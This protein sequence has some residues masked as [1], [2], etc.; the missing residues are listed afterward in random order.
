VVHIFCLGNIPGSDF[1][2]GLTIPSQVA[3][4]PTMS[5]CNPVYSGTLWRVHVQD[6]V[7]QIV[8]LECLG[9]VPGGT[10]LQGNSVANS[11]ALTGAQTDAGTGWK[12]TRTGSTVNFQLSGGTVYL[13]GLTVP[14]QVGLAPS[15]ASQYSGTGWQLW[16]A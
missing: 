7:N 5:S 16:Q 10:W 6:P 4:A 12:V 15:T 9:N 2:N 13:N 11:I 1:L 14:G 3:L 8:N